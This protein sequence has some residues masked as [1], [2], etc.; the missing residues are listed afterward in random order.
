MRFLSLFAGVGG[1]DLG[2]ERAGMR[3]VAQVEL[4]D[5]CRSILARRWP[6]VP[7]FKDVRTFT[8]PQLRG[9]VDLV[10]GGFPCQDISSAG[11]KAGIGGARS[12]LWKEMLRIVR[13]F[14]PS[15]VL[16][17]NVAALR[18]RGLD[19][20]LGDLAASGFNAEWDCLPAAAFGA[21]HLRDRL[22]IVAHAKRLGRD[23]ASVLPDGDEAEPRPRAPTQNGGVVEGLGR[24]YRAYPRDLRMDDGAAAAVDRIRGCGNAVYPPTAEWLGRQILAFDRPSK[25][26]QPPIDPRSNRRQ[27]A[28]FRA[29]LARTF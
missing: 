3:C 7:K 21:P 16:V 28:Q 1:M 12:G 4:D 24:R 13:S 8:R 19:V 6:R 18:S 11:K 23:G 10:A 15:Y 17:E 20:V 9:R 2:L 26:R 14:R 22:F 27:I 25:G 29:Q 5:Y